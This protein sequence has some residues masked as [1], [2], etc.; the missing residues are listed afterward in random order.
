[1]L[2]VTANSSKRKYLK[3]RDQKDKGKGG[4]QYGQAS[5][6]SGT[7]AS[8]IARCEEKERNTNIGARLLTEFHV[9]VYCRDPIEWH[10]IAS[11]GDQRHKRRQTEEEQK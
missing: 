1:M 11:N 10:N 8:D 4:E 7:I 6:S 9:P 2:T 3:G 5:D